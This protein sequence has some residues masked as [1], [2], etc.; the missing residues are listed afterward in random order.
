MP[1]AG[2]LIFDH[3]NTTQSAMQ[4]ACTFAVEEIWRVAA[5]PDAAVFG[6]PGEN[7]GSGTRSLG[8]RCAEKTG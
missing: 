4:E 2:P 1:K 5:R 3:L 8:F 6:V 7:R